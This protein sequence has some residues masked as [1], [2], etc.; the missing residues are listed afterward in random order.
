MKD[1]LNFYWWFEERLRYSKIK[2]GTYN[3]KKLNVVY[4][5][6]K[7]FRPNLPVSDINY[8]FLQDFEVHLLSIGNCTNT[9]ADNLFR[10]KIIVNEIVRSGVIEYH[11]NPFLHYKIQFKRTEKKRISIED[12]RK[13]ENADL[14]ANPNWELARDIY[15]FSFYCAGIR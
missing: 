2:H 12:V 14:S 6:L 8:K 9:T 15:I 13:F 11:K 5:K 7:A 3:W 1:E 10:V 4:N